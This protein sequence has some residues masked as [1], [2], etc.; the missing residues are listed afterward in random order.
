MKIIKIFFILVLLSINLASLRKRIKSKTK[1]DEDVLYGWDTYNEDKL[2]EEDSDPENN[3]NI[4]PRMSQIFINGKTTL[5]EK[6]EHVYEKNL[7]TRENYSNLDV[8]KYEV[9]TGVV[10][11]DITEAKASIYAKSNSDLQLKSNNNADIKINGLHKKALNY[12]SLTIKDLNKPFFEKIKSLIEPSFF[13]KVDCKSKS[14]R[15]H[16]KIF[17]DYGT[18]FI[19]ELYYGYIKYTEYEDTYEQAKID[20]EVKVDASANDRGCFGLISCA[21]KRVK[22]DQTIKK[23]SVKLTGTYGEEE[24]NKRKVVAK[25]MEGLWNL[26]LNSNFNLSENE[27]ITSEIIPKIL[28]QFKEKLSKKIRNES[29]KS[30]LEPEPL[31]EKIKSNINGKLIKFLLNLSTCYREKLQEIE[32]KKSEV[33]ITEIR[34]FEDQSGESDELKNCLGNFK[35][36]SN[37]KGEW[38]PVEKQTCNGVV[39]LKEYTYFRDRFIICYKLEEI[40][41]AKFYVSR[42]SITRESNTCTSKDNLIPLQEIFF[43]DYNTVKLCPLA[44]NFVE[45]S[46]SKFKEKYIEAKDGLR[47]LLAQNIPVGE[48]CQSVVKRN[49]TYNCLCNSNLNSDTSWSIKDISIY[50]CFSTDIRL[51]ST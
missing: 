7:E 1:G 51:G 50:L 20:S 11:N 35:S 45:T 26:F 36:R 24:E 30:K 49:V 6:K 4:F 43:K 34:T 23:R 39:C 8:L 38:Y 42:F 32:D 46:L 37:K 15:E 10:T 13:E 21:S 16:R 18:S 14:T 2:K 31:T 44:K 47:Y 22:E 9:K 17:D 25:K 33:I 28:P 12:G 19:S 27:E 41:T 5:W 48:R 3:T 40:K 29:D